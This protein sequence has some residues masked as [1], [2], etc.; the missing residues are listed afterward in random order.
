MKN[1]I[2][3]IFLS[4]IS[5]IVTSLQVFFGSLWYGIVLVSI[6]QIC[7]IGTSA[8]TFDFFVLTVIKFSAFVTTIVMII[9]LVISLLEKKITNGLK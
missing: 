6:W 8:M 4:V 2:E 1:L 3:I 5:F 7:T 9:I